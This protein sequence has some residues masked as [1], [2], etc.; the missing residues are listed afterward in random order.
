MPRK[1]KMVNS[2][3]SES[4]ICKI[5]GFMLTALLVTLVAASSVLANPHTVS[6]IAGHD[7]WMSVIIV[8]VSGA[9]LVYI[10]YRLSLLFP[11][12]TLIEYLPAIVGKL[13]GKIIGLGY[14]LVLI[15]LTATVLREALVFFYATGIFAYTPEVIVGLCMVIAVTYGVWAGLE[16]IARTLSFYWVGLGLIY[17]VF[18]FITIPAMQFEVLLPLGE[19]G[20]STILQGSLGPHGFRGELF[21][22]AM[23][24]PYCRNSREGYK[25]GILAN[26]LISVFIIITTIACIAVLGVDTTARSLYGPFFLADFVQP[27]GIKIFLVSVWVV[28]FWGKLAL[29]QFALTDGTAQLLGLKEHRPVILPIGIIGL[30]FSLTFYRNVPDIFESI[31]RTLPGMMLFFGFLIPTFLLIA[32]SIKAGAK[33][34]AEKP[35]IAAPFTQN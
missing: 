1:G 6:R 25:A 34:K 14:L 7:G 33:L 22:L 28:S 35:T 21:V 23:L 27:V 5:D 10:L 24:F 20:W 26:L 15:Y 2:M 19:V 32:A 18:I 3:K 31:L 30:V 8:T 29:L 9:Y 16:V 4:G 17:A 13:A 11:G 12:Q